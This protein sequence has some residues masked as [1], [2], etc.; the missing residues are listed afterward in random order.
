MINHMKIGKRMKK[1]K[2][3]KL[4]AISILKLNMSIIIKELFVLLFLFSFLTCRS[5]DKV[6]GKGEME[7]IIETCITAFRTHYVYPDQ[8][9][10][11][12]K[13]VNI[14][15]KSGEYDSFTNLYEFVKQIK[16]DFR[17]VSNDRHIWID[18]MENLPVKNSNVSDQEK[19]NEL[20]KSNFGFTKYEL[21]EG[22]VAYLKLDGFV[23]VKYG[24]DTAAA[25]MNKLSN[26]DAIILDLRQNHG[27]NGNMVRFISSHFFENKVQMNSLY[28]READSLA[29]D[30]TDPSI[31]GKLLVNQKLYIL[32]STN[33]ASAAESFTNLMKNY[34]RATIVGEHTRGAG[35]WVETYKFSEL[36][37]FLEIP[38]ARPIN[39]ITK[40][41]WEGTGIIPDIKISE[42]KALDKAVALALKEL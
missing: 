20:H 34:N 25:Y 3:S 39:P 4:I 9:L 37:I 29:T 28:F 30:W 35:H 11:M 16:I 38:V 22:N 7:C 32:T 36:G 5:Q 26:S 12:E 21:L 27:G 31:P 19:I 13:K 23:D 40:K 1:I 15:F 41:G 42:D 33:T 17:S 18:I 8:V 10:E 2:K 14:K 6:L 24:R